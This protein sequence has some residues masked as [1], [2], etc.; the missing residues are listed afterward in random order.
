M[1]KLWK[2][3]KHLDHSETISVLR[4]FSMLLQEKMNNE[5]YNNIEKITLG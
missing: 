2:K 5:V 3:E 4:N 1:E